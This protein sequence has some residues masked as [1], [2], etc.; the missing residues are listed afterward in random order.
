MSALLA[1]A[2]ETVLVMLPCADAPP[3]KPEAPFASVLTKTARAPV[4]ELEVVDEVL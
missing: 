4:L 1:T 3:V 2:P